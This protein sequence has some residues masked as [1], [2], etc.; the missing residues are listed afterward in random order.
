M[1]TSI[2]TIFLVVQGQHILKE[3]DLDRFADEVVLSA[4]QKVAE[5]GRVDFAQPPCFVQG[6]EHLLHPFRFRLQAFDPPHIALD[7]DNNQKLP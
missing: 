6:R 5:A 1:G 4:E 2:W 7:Q 3:I